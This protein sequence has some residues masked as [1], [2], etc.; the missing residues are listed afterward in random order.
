MA[1]LGRSGT[2]AALG[3]TSSPGEAHRFDRTHLTV[4]VDRFG[5]SAN[6][7]RAALL[8]AGHADDRDE[9]TELLAMCGLLPE[10]S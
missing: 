5:H 1:T 4:G 3:G 10:P 2:S 6:Q 8:V 7:R 9:L